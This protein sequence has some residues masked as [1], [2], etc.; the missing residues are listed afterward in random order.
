VIV[1]VISM[2]KNLLR[3]AAVL[4]VGVSAAGCSS[5]PD[6]IDPTSWV[7]D[8]SAQ[9]ADD[10]GQAPDLADIPSKPH[11]STPDD[12]KQVAD[13]LAADRSQATYSAD[14]L[15]A[16]NETSAP[17]PADAP[18]PDR[19]GAHANIEEDAQSTPST[20]ASATA[21]DTSSESGTTEASAPP[22][23]RVATAEASH[24]QPQRSPAAAASTSSAP[25]AVA[26]SDASL[27]FRPSAAP[28]LDPSVAQFVSPSVLSR[29]R[30]T[31]SLSPDSAV[32]PPSATETKSSGQHK[33]HKSAEGEGG[34]EQMTGDVVANM[35]AVDTPGASLSAYADANGNAPAA[36]VFFPGDGTTLNASS[37]AKVKQVVQAYQA[38]GNQG[39]I[40]V[41]GHS[42]SRTPNMPIE[43]HLALIFQR[44]QDRANA[45]AHELIKLGVPAAKVLVEAVGD[46][47]PRYYES[48]PKGEEGNRRAEI[49]LQP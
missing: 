47:Q 35:D 37:R 40:K 33:R 16:G 1:G 2:T 10:S 14:A 3:L 13:S 21:S 25:S 46:S 41:V 18:P 49:F 31:A 19:S 42:S 15:R 26:Q 23:P 39:F 17:P 44:S 11:A 20:P 38:K 48:M 28:A 12:Q 34:P 45:V 32:A 7:G 8:N 29:Y 36:V 6:W 22:P 30:H 5:V 43:K 4:A 24:V 9:T 27:G